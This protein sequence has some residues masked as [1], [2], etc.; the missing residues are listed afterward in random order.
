MA[1]SKAVTKADLKLVYDF[2][3]GIVGV[4]GKH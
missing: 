2:T 1:V 3:P 4:L